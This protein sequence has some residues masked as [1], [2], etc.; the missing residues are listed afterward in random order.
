MNSRSVNVKQL[1]EG[2][3]ELYSGNQRRG[4]TMPQEKTSGTDNSDDTRDDLR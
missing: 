2:K 1:T 3:M 4:A